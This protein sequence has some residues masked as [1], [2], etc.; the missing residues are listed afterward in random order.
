[1]KNILKKY[2]NYKNNYHIKQNNIYKYQE[3]FQ[4]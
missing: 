2:K 1:M 3:N 4:L